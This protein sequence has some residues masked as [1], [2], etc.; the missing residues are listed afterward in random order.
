[1]ARISQPRQIRVENHVN[2]VNLDKLGLELVNQIMVENLVNLD[3]L[4]LGTRHPWQIRV[5]SLTK[6]DKLGLELVNLE[7]LGLGTHQAL[8][9]R[10]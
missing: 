9:L 1:M 4:G 6:D 3:K 2:L 8:G 5:R 7:E 10:P